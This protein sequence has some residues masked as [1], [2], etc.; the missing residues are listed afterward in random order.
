MVHSSLKMSL[1][2]MAS[3]NISVRRTIRWS[4]RGWSLAVGWLVEKLVGVLVEALVEKLVDALIEGLVGTMV[5][6]L[7]EALVFELVEGLVEALVVALVEVL[8]EALVEALVELLVEAVV[9]L[10]RASLRSR[11]WLVGVLQVKHPCCMQREFLR[12]VF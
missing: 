12:Q 9:T 2:W 3:W 6:A 11:T 1:S 7:V 10:S 4:G 5:E 8:V